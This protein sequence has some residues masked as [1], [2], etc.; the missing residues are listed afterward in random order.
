MQLSQRHMYVSTSLFFSPF[1]F[2]YFLWKHDR[3]TSWMSVTLWLSAIIGLRLS[4]FLKILFF[5]SLRNAKCITKKAPAGIRE[6]ADGLIHRMRINFGEASRASEVERCGRKEDRKVAFWRID[7]SRRRRPTSIH[8]DDSC[9]AHCEHKHAQAL[10]VYAQ[11]VGGLD[12]MASIRSNNVFMADL[13]RAPRFLDGKMLGS[14]WPGRRRTA[15][16]PGS[17]R[18][19]CSSKLRSGSQ[20][21]AEDARKGSPGS[22]VCHDG[23]YRISVV[24]KQ[25]YVPGLSI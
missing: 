23:D 21:R 12:V 17:Q 15:D 9:R 13:E 7:F 22:I 24:V 18:V 5:S 11:Y 6:L 19:S 4:D 10:S 8:R 25:V 16:N 14:S 20:A 1:I 2:A 3:F